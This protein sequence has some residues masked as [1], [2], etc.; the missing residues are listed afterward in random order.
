MCPEQKDKKWNY[1]LGK[2]HSMTEEIRDLFNQ[3]LEQ[4]SEGAEQRD[5]V[6][7][8]WAGVSRNDWRYRSRNL[9][10]RLISSTEIAKK[11]EPEA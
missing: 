2:F 8:C 7:G 4:G 5:C 9:K 10:F 11:S 3:F 1:R 6:K